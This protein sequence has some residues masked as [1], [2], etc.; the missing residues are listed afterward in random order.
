MI[1]ADGQHAGVLDNAVGIN[2]IIGRATADID[3]EGTH[4]LLLVAQQRQRRRQSVKDDVVN[5]QLQA[6]DGANGI[7]E[8]VEIPMLTDG[9]NHVVLGGQ[10]DRFGVLNHVLNIHLRY[11]PIR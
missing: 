8:P 5:L 4:F 10:I 2:N 1:P 11:L 3:H 6:F 7:L 9:V